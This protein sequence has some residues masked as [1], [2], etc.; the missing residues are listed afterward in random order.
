MI[1]KYEGVDTQLLVP[2]TS[3]VSVKVEVRGRPRFFVQ[4]TYELRDRFDEVGNEISDRRL[5]GILIDNLVRK[6]N[7]LHFNYAKGTEG[8]VGI[9]K[10]ELA[11]RT[12]VQPQVYIR[13]S[14]T[15]L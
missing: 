6:Y 14:T 8:V 1:K 15:T 13:K 2:A 10:A 7:I 4:Y 11:I 12:T 9:Y 3:A 5:M